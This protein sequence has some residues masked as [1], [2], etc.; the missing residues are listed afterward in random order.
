VYRKY[1]AVGSVVLFL[2]FIAIALDDYNQAWR[3]YQR[4]YY[5]TL[6]VRKEG[7]LN[8]LDRLSIEM[9]K[10][11][12][13]DNKVVTEAGRSA[14][15]CMV[16]HINTGAPGFNQQPLKDLL[17]EHAALSQI[18][19]QL[20][21]D[22]VGCTACH[23]GVG[24]AT[25]AEQAHDGLRDRFSD[26]FEASLA[27]LRSEEGMVRQSGIEEIRWMVG[28]DFGFV[29]SDPA[30]VRA[31]AVARIQEWWELHKGTFLAEGLGERASPF[32]T[33]NPQASLIEDRTDITIA[34]EPEKFIGSASCLGCHTGPHPGGTA[35][36]PP[37]NQAH[38]E[39]WYQPDY[40]TSEHS[41]VFKDHPF[42]DKELLKTMDL[43]CEACHGPGSQYAKLMMK[44]LAFQF[45]GR[46]AEAAALIGQGRAIA[47]A[48]ALRNVEDPRIWGI[49]ELLIAEAAQKAPIVQIVQSGSQQVQTGSQQM[50][51]PPQ[52]LLPLG[53]CP[54]AGS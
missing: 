45:Q 53:G 29:F 40:M 24:N 7:H 21:F 1:F 54:S 43:T 27:K 41:D 5:T 39:R 32:K 28:D 47:C 26:V 13:D 49:F 42:I 25:T 22:K 10:I 33:V 2:V 38:L 36:I 6:Q 8:L 19:N 16:C 3:A 23:G 11:N 34:G 51:M 52:F 46:T 14:D 30:P 48:N 9:T 12:L 44:G 50:A 20:P 18:I 17:A 37:S 35:Y 4:E 15:M 31:Q